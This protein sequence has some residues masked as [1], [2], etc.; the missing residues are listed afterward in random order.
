MI[1]LSHMIAFGLVAHLGAMAGRQWIER[2]AAAPANPPAKTRP[3][4]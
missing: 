4:R 3:I 1:L 2:H